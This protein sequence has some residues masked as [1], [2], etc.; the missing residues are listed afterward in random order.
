MSF[1][2][3]IASLG[4]PSF[5]IQISHQDVQDLPD[6]V[7]REEVWNLFMKLGVT[8]TFSQYQSRMDVEVVWVKTEKGWCVDVYEGEAGKKLKRRRAVK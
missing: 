3:L 7:T 5:R 6:A 4:Q 2:D 8:I 1:A